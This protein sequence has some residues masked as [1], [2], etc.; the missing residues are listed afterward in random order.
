MRKLTK[1]AALIV[2][3]F[4]QSQLVGAA[5]FFY[6]G[7]SKTLLVMGE[8]VPEDV[9]EFRHFVS[10]KNVET[11]ILRGPGGALLAA[12]AIANEIQ[13]KGLRTVVPEKGECASACS[14]MFI[15]G[16]DRKLEEGSRLGFHLPFLAL[17]PES[18]KSYCQTVAPKPTGRRNFEYLLNEQSDPKCLTETY[19]MGF[20]HL[21]LFSKVIRES[22]ISNEVID[23][24]IETPPESM[25]WFD[26]D[27]AKGL[28]LVN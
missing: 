13:A 6:L 12:F 22:D 7:E 21:S 4:V 18:V 27:E 15:A 19:R 5:E 25:S 3:S 28:N 20:L 16:K 24:M 8:T 1:L 23:I 14:L 26:A 11:V 9:G 17:E 2:C 10:E